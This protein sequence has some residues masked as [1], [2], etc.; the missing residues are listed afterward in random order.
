[1][2]VA[3]IPCVVRRM[4]A[5]LFVVNTAL[6]CLSG[7]VCAQAADPM[8]PVAFLAGGTWLGEGKL[9][10]GSAL[11]VEVRYFWGPT[12]RVLHFETYDLAGEQRKLIYEGI[13][14]FDAKRGKI[15]QYNFKP[16]GEIDESELTEASSKGYEVRGANTRSLVHYL[17]T[18]VFRW[19]LRALRAGEWKVILD[20]TYQ[21]RS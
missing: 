17:S 16:T 8:G 10:D 4:L 5:V 6:N 20:A 11:R 13:L 3:G 18:N 19:E 14:F 9:P 2:I 12:K 1:M 7:M 21:R 15:V